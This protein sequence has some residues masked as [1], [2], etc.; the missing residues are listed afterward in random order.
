[1]NGPVTEINV[2]EYRTQFHDQSDSEY[3]L[4]DV[5]EVEEFAVGRIPGAINIPLSELEAR[6]A[7]VEKDKPIV[8]VCRTGGRS[9]MA[10][11]FMAFHGY[12]DLFNV[13]GGTLGWAQRKLPLDKD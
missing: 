1:M 3:L 5:R 4:L 13:N 2:D 10:A 8:L 12:K 9:A 6:L 11:Q 7:E